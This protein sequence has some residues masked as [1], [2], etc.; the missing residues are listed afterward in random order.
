MKLGEK[1]ELFSRCLSQL[2]T[3]IFLNGYDV[4]MGDVLA[5]DGH[6]E[7][8]LHYQ[9]LAADLNLFYKGVYQTATE[10]H[11]QFGEYWENLHPL[12]T[13]GGRFDDGGHYSITHEG[14]K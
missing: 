7:N 1:Q 12:C 2:L 5:H 14:R 13:W 4:R 11:K 3:H 6:M 8:S 10:D 9:K